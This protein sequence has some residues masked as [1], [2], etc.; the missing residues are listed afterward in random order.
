MFAIAFFLTA[1]IIV[2]M[3]AWSTL[4][5]HPHETLFNFI[6]SMLA[7]MMWEFVLILVIHYC[8]DKFHS[9]D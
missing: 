4:T 6:C 3:A 5:F 8:D 7:G 2:S 9:R 1:A